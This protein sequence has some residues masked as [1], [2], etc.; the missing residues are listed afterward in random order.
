[1]AR[2]VAVLF[3]LDGTL[4]DT[5]PFILAGVRHAFEGRARAPTDA[6]WIAGIGTPLRDQLAPFAAGP[7]DVDWLFQRYRAFWLAEHDRRT[8]LFPGAEALVRTLAARG[9]PLAIITAKIEAG[10]ERTLAHVGLRALFGAVV[11]ADTVARAK[12]DPMPVHHALAKLDR[13]P[14]EALMIGDSPHDLAA[15][16][17]AGTATAGVLWGA[18]S[19]AALAPLADRLLPAMADVLTAVEELQARVDAGPW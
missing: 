3:D 5:V 1:M 18:A 6:D 17:G 8:R 12:P 9:H 14:A 15:G 2:P 7:A 4:V 13:T 19:G 10:A 16:R 11:A